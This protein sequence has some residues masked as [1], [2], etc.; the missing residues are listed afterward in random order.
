MM[1]NDIYEIA[2]TLLLIRGDS[3]RESETN[4]NVQSTDRPYKRVLT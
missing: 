4:S 2:K 3:K 1:R